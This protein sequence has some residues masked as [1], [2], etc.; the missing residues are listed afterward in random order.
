MTLLTSISVYLKQAFKIFK[1]AKHS[2][3]ELARATFKKAKLLKS[4]SSESEYQATLQEA[5][6]IRKQILP[7][8]FRPMDKISDAEYDLLVPFWSR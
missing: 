2:A 8:D 4:I 7:G 6:E 5:Y 1:A 3:N